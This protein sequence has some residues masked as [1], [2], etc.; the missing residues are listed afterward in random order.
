MDRRSLVA[1]GVPITIRGGGGG[2]VGV[3]PEESIGY[4]D[5]DHSQQQQRLQPQQQQ[6][7]RGFQ[8]GR[9][10]ATSSAEFMDANTDTASDVRRSRALSSV[11]RA[12]VVGGGGGSGGGG[13]GRLERAGLVG[14]AGS[15]ARTWKGTSMYGGYTDYGNYGGGANDR[16][17]PEVDT[18]FVTMSALMNEDHSASQ[19][20]RRSDQYMHSNASY[21]GN[22]IQHLS[23][24]SVPASLRPLKE[25]AT[26][27]T[28]PA[29]ARRAVMS[30]SLLPVPKPISPQAIASAQ[31][32]QSS[33]K[34]FPA[35]EPQ[36]A[37]HNGS[38]RQINDAQRAIHTADASLTY[39]YPETSSAP[40]ASVPSVVNHQAQYQQSSAPKSSQSATSSARTAQSSAR[41][42]P[43]TTTNGTGYGD[44]KYSRVRQQQKQASPVVSE[45]RAR[46]AT[47]RAPSAN[48]NPTSS[49]AEGRTWRS[50][51][52]A[53]TVNGVGARRPNSP[54]R[55]TSKQRNA[56]PRSRSVPRTGTR[57]TYG[58]PSAK[59]LKLPLTPEATMTYYKDLLTPYE[60]REVYEYK[61][62]YFAGA[63]TVEKIGGLRRRSGADRAEIANVSG[64]TKDDDKAVYNNGYDDSRGDY[65]LTKHD[66]IG[67][68]YEILSLL[69][70]GSFGQVVKCY[71]H[72][73][74]ANVALKIIRNK[75]RFEKQGAVE[76][77]VL[78]KLKSEDPDDANS[79]IHMGEH[80]YFRGHLCITFELLGINLYEWL[81][82]G[83]F[84]GVH[85]GVIRRFTVQILHCLQLLRQQRIVHC[86]LKPENVLLRDPSI[87]APSRSDSNLHG[88]NSTGSDSTR[89][90]SSPSSTPYD[91]DPTSR[92]Y[93]IKVIDFGSSCFEDEKVYTYVQSRF[94]RSP[95]VILGIS[96]NVSIDMWSL[97][98]ILAE[99]YTGYPL[100]PGENEQEQLSCIMEVKGV[101]DMSFVDRGTRRKLFFDPSGAP[102]IVPNSKG[103]KRRPATKSLSAVLRCQDTLF[104]NFIERCLTWDPEKRMSPEEGLNHEWILQGERTNTPGARSSSR[105]VSTS[106]GGRYANNSAAGTAGGAAFRR[107]QSAGT[108]EVG[109]SAGAGKTGGG[110]GRPRFGTAINSSAAGA[111]TG[112]AGYASNANGPVSGGARQSIMGGGGVN[113]S[114][115]LSGRKQSLP[116]VINT[117]GYSSASH[118]PP[119]QRSAGY[120]APQTQQQT[121]TSP[122]T[123]L[124]YRGDGYASGLPPI[125][126][127][128]GTNAS[129]NTT[130]TSGTGAT[131]GAPSS[132]SSEHRKSTYRMSMAPSAAT[133]TA[134]TNAASATSTAAVVNG[135]RGYGFG[136][137]AAG[138]ASAGGYGEYRQSRYEGGS[139]GAGGLAGVG[140]T[141]T[142]RRSGGGRAE[143]NGYAQWR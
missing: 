58:P 24:V 65:Y 126:Y 127:A 1:G 7:H 117:A 9:L 82:A 130:A 107:K 50:G 42:T 134:T 81:K 26:G 43:S 109:N 37:P 12:D 86:D 93:D 105:S 124:Y 89:H 110:A 6:Q 90:R 41:Q 96:Y 67:Y 28:S 25:T 40:A 63:A 118:V 27:P 78:D 133:A 121:P 23:A 95:E 137:N 48:A 17:D 104:V 32:L 52:A 3:P 103:K 36:S 115:I 57:S 44:S 38:T 91:F 108:L 4:G 141:G 16:S 101:P 11:T 71:D 62:I 29:N 114:S 140:T 77:K 102:R 49:A 53:G 142:G 131:T 113:G 8:P 73:A 20:S 112:N 19:A 80:F 99:L 39:S 138:G 87:Q 72:K 119:S 111:G 120:S 15:E 98:C 122:R 61:E 47:G 76:V 97:G 125:S 132:A 88:A 66:H 116:A 69:G 5:D 68:R 35:R 85:L 46:S 135:A 33:L 22:N 84:R 55:D 100:F 56:S 64:T 136:N 14:T 139:K 54:S 70:K 31:A 18:V 74:K 45:G 2:L 94:Y 60:Q 83:G 128:T 79:I 13:G 129:G 59:D 143:G 34:Y 106:P 92:N 21:T 75:K 51:A 123:S 30:K 10:R